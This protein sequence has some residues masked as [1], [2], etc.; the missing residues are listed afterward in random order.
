[1]IDIRQ[2]ENSRSGRSVAILGGGPSLLKDIYRLP[3]DVDLIGVNQHALLLPLDFVVFL[4]AAIWELVKDHPCLKVSHHKIEHPKMVWSGV[5]PDYGLSGAAALWIAEF[6]G[7]NEIM[8]CGFDCYA[9]KRRYWHSPVDED[10][11]A[12]AYQNDIRIWDLV[13]THLKYPE[14]IKFMSG[15]MMEKWQ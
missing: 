3:E 12:N 4:D 15:P 13:R 14:R 6:L 7:Y 1:M 8:V 9:Q 11:K 10:F 2:I 5:C